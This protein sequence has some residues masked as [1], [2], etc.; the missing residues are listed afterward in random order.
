MR[1][2]LER[3]DH[4]PSPSASQRPHVP[5]S[6]QTELGPPKRPGMQVYVQLALFISTSCQK[7]ASTIPVVC[8][9]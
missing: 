1:A 6:T 4:E 9:F 5:L 3:L 2:E 7:S 8:L